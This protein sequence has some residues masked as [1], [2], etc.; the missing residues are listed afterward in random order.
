MCWIVYFYC[1]K[2]AFSWWKLPFVSY[3]VKMLCLPSGCRRT[4]WPR[5]PPRPR[6][7]LS[8][9]ERRSSRP[10]PRPPWSPAHQHR[11]DTGHMRH[12]HCHLTSHPSQPL[13]Q[14]HGSGWG[15]GLSVV[16]EVVFSVVVAVV[17]LGTSPPQVT[18]RKGSS[19]QSLTSPSPHL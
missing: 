13:P 1:Y 7:R 4:E 19:S 16:L 17:V 2:D 12:Q 5:P 8:R 18:F 11:E 3:F 14:V 10:R 9:T 6:P 15:P